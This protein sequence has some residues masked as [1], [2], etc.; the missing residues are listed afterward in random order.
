MK[1]VAR[2][3][4]NDTAFMRRREFIT[5]VGAAASWPLAARAQQA[6]PVVGF[7]RSTAAA[8]R[9]GGACVADRGAGTTAD[10]AGDRVPQS[11]IA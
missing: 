8:A 10:N 1:S 2:L 6:M 9:R 3:R 11:H 5:L 7:L 4:T